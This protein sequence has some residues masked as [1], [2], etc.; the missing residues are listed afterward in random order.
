MFNF[1]KK[2]KIMIRVAFLQFFV[3]NQ[4]FFV[5]D[6]F[7][8]PSRKS[9]IISRKSENLRMMTRF[10]MILRAKKVIYLWY[11]DRFWKSSVHDLVRQLSVV[12]RESRLKNAYCLQFCGG[13]GRSF[14]ADWKTWKTCFSM[15]KYHN[16]LK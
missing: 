6:A 16:F 13:N 9:S 4:I 3:E 10:C 11:F 1:H 12:F 2:Y 15:K 5:T 7:A 8:M 14:W